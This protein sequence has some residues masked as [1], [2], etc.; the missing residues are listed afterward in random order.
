MKSI[1]DMLTSVWPS[2]RAMFAA[3]PPRRPACPHCGGG[4]CFGACQFERERRAVGG[5]GD[6]VARGAA[7]GGEEGSVGRSGEGER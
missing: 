7:G 1:L 6:Q 2:L 4:R 3:P 5:D